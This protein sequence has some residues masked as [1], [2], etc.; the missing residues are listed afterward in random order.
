MKQCAAIAIQ[1]WVRAYFEFQHG[2]VSHTNNSAQGY[3]VIP[4]MQSKKR[5]NQDLNQFVWSN[6]ALLEALNDFIDAKRDNTIAHM[7]SDLCELAGALQHTLH[8]NQR[9]IESLRGQSDAAYTQVL[10][11]FFLLFCFFC[12]VS[13]LVAGPDAAYTQVLPHPAYVCMQVC[14]CACMY[15]CMCVCLSADSPA[16]CALYP[17]LCY[18][19][20]NP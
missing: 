7:R 16:P 1:R 17:A 13:A 20:P 15:V 12:A 10:F 18:L 3:M 8:Y 2:R 4:D 5:K 19:I 14:M 9:T 11:F 6:V